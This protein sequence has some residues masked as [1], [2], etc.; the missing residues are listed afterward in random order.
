M[1]AKAKLTTK[2]GDVFFGDIYEIDPRNRHLVWVNYSLNDLYSQQI[3]DE[4]AKCAN[5]HG[6]DISD[7]CRIDEVLVN[8]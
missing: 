5:K 3:L 4:G 7:I 6:V 1:K 8:D 2:S